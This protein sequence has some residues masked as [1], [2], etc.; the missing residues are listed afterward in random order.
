MSARRSVDIREGY[1]EYVNPFLGA[2]LKKLRLDKVFIA[3][4]GAYLFDDEG[5]TYLDFL[6]NYGATLLGHNYPPLKAALEEYLAA[7]KPTFV[8][9]SMGSEATKL[10]KKLVDLSPKS[11]KKV[12]FTNSGAESV[13]LCIK[14]A[15]AATGRQRV[16]TAANSFHG[17]T[18]GALSASRALRREGWQAQAMYDRAATTLEEARGRL[19]R[20][21]RAQELAR[22]ALDYSVLTAE[23]DGVVTAAPIEPGQAVVPGQ[24][25]VRL[26]R[27]DEKEAAA[28]IPETMAG[29]VGR[30]EAV[31]TL[32][33]DP[34]KRYAARLRELAPVSDPVTRTY[35]ARFSI[36]AADGKL[37]LGMSATLTVT[38]PAGGDVAQLPLTALVNRGSGPCLWM[39][40]DSGRLRLLPVKVQ[41][42]DA[43]SV[44]I[45]SGVPEGA[46]A[47][48]LGVQKLDEGQTV[49]T[50][51]R[52][53]F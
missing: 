32:W 34:S 4:K 48:L 2:L 15:R 8:Q 35:A 3:G 16:L 45:T 49:R 12:V 19:T 44:F 40:E 43:T 18:I 28:A 22:N 27:L 53:T 37:I 42:Y 41:S 26:A 5:N 31:L 7:N 9:P 52:L 17:K 46:S 11:L 13:E 10:A 14:V 51:S 1:C 36:P 20:A 47:V 30:G 23:A 21:E 25:A 39:V 6:S 33:S 50:V 38:L 29:E 24:L